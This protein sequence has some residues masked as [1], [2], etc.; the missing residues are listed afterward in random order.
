MIRRDPRIWVLVILAAMLGAAPMAA[1]QSADKGAAT[2]S[3]WLVR[4]C[5]FLGI[6]R[7]QALEIF[8]SGAPS[9]PGD[10]GAAIWEMTAEGRDAGP[11]A[12]D[13]AYRW[14]VRSPGGDRV[15]ALRAGRVCVLRRGGPCNDLP[16][17][18]GPGVVQLLAWTADGIAGITADGHVAR[19]DPVSGRLEAGEVVPEAQ[20]PEIGTAA[21]TC[22]DAYLDVT[23]GVPDARTGRT[24]VDIVIERRKQFGDAGLWEG[25]VLT[26]GSPR[27]KNLDPSFSADCR[28][29][30]FVA[31]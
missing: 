31:R 15:A 2:D 1:G 28:H 23:T 18:D 5:T 10:E 6:R 30:L 16:G 21:R 20:R 14:P 9:A 17:G 27:V 26:L 19:I 24:R 25:T 11:L 4:V 22:G 7:P 29:V 13:G 8:R 3:G 12:T